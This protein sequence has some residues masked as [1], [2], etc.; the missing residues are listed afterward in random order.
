MGGCVAEGYSKQSSKYGGAEALRRLVRLKERAEASGQ[1]TAARDAVA[2]PWG[3]A[4]CHAVKPRGKDFAAIT[5][6]ASQYFPQ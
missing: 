6:Q 3:A 5:A 2:G 1:G 4:C